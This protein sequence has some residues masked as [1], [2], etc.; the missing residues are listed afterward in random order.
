M[1]GIIEYLVITMAVIGMSMACAILKGGG[2]SFH[3]FL[4]SAA[5]GIALLVWI[6]LFPV[7][8]ISISI[9]ILVA[10][11]FSPNPSGVSGE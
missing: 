7:Y 4:V 8:M 3:I 5:I 2:F 6:P 1:S 10:M 11:L 9:L